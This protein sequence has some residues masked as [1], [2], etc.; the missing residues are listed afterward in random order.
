MI[1]SNGARARKLPISLIGLPSSSA[2]TAETLGPL[3][4]PC[5]AASRNG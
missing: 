5:R 4:R 1:G 2:I 3:F